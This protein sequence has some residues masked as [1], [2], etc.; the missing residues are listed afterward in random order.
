[1]RAFNPGA[2]R[3][4]RSSTRRA[5]EDLACAPSSR[6][7]RRRRAPCCAAARPAASSS[8]AGDGALAVMELQRAGGKRLAAAA[9]LAGSPVAPRRARFGAD[10]CLK[11]S[12]SRA[13]VVGRVLA[14][15]SLDA[16]LAAR[17]V[18]RAAA[19]GAASAPRSRTSP[20][21]RCAFSASSTRC[22]MRCS[23]G[24]SSD[25]ALRAPAARRALPA[26]PTRAPR[27]TRSS[28]TRCALRARSASLRRKGLVNAV[29]RNF[30]RKR[31][32]R[33]T[34]RARD[35]AG[36][37]SHPQ[38]WIDK[39][40]A[41]YPQHYEQHARE[42]EPA[43]AAHAAREPRGAPSVG[44]LS[45][46]ARRARASPRDALGGERGHAR[47]RRC[48][49]ERIP[50]SPKA[51]V[52]VQDAAAQLR[53]AAAR[54]ARTG[55]ACSTRARR[56]GGKTAHILELRRRR[57]DRARQRRG[58]ARARARRIS[59]GCGLAAQLVVRRCG[60]SRAA[61]WD[62]EPFDAHPR[63][64]AVLGLGC[65]APPS[66]HQVAAARERHRAVRAAPAR[67]ARRA[68]ADCSRL[69]VNCCTQRARCFTRKTSEQIER[70][71]ERHRDARR[72]TLPAAAYQRTTARGPDSS[73]RHA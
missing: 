66:R 43:S 61:W 49:S 34:P 40:R 65:R 9:F 73:G 69:M 72:L 22:S 18:A 62:G 42:R 50:G 11:S 63:R 30:L 44:R 29:L 39:L 3:A 67:H 20:T 31:D 47:A 24:R 38:W 45:R 14:G 55:S 4:R 6:R 70:F 48:P 58:A 51:L 16:E 23:S 59:R 41:Q 64:R 35:R 54:R 36:R 71:L 8:P 5:A 68:L 28:I 27:R 60:A 15:R 57:S 52:S 7:R 10:R 32:A 53:G 12:G 1:M 25:D 33:S 17:L 37:Y 21:A 13:A 19:D 2:R 26:R 56:P 46:A